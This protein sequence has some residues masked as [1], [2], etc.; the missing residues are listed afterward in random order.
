MASKKLK[1]FIDAEVLVVPHFSGIGHYT[2]E[3][4]RGLDDILDTRQD[5]EVTLGVYF[6]KLPKIYSYGFKNFKFKRFHSHGKH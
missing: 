1:V 3:L 6:R 4:L 5:V 2:L